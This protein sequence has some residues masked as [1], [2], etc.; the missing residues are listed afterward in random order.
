MMYNREHRNQIEENFPKGTK[1]RLL[2]MDDPQAPKVGTLGIVE[3]VDS[4]GTIHVKWE[5]GS[6][7]GVIIGEDV[8]EIV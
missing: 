5:N 6:G 7:L 2:K 8:I 4:M 3:Y 1:V